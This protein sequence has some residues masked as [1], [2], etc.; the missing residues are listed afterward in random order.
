MFH[1]KQ[2]RPKRY[3]LDRF[4]RFLVSYFSDLE[5]YFSKLEMTNFFASS[6]AITIHKRITNTSQIPIPNPHPPH[7][8]S[9]ETS[10]SIQVGYTLLTT[11]QIGYQPI[12]NHKISLFYYSN[13]H[14]IFT[15]ENSTFRNKTIHSMSYFSAQ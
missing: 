11:A 3:I 5:G 4:F 2:I 10:T 8:Q 9:L 12:S 7:P 15:T 1:V 6:V 14:K 13:H